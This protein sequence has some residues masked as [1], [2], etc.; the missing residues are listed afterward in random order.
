MGQKVHPLGVRLGFNKMWDAKWFSK[1]NVPDFIQEDL[2]IRD[3]IK[4]KFFNAG[5]GKII[6]ERAGKSIRVNIYTARPGLVIGKRGSD[7]EVLKTEME[8]MTDSQININII[9]I[10]KPELDAQIVAEDIAQQLLKRGSFRRILKKTISRSMAGGAQGIKIKVSGRLNGAEIAR[11][12]WMKEGRIPL[13][14]LKANICYGFAE[15]NTSYG[16]IGVK[17]WIF[18]E[19][20]FEKKLKQRIA[21]DPGAAEKAKTSRESTDGKEKVAQDKEESKAGSQAAGDVVETKSV[22]EVKKVEPD[23]SDSKVDSSEDKKTVE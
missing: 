3:F 11:T 13:Q 23:K 6:I 2:A 1:R 8:Q 19:D 18:I 7:I 4:K 16:K 15:S 21:G 9:P 17:V 5:I 20:D 12:E 14:T 22:D 10:K